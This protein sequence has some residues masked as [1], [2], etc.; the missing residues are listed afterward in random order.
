MAVFLFGVSELCSCFA[1]HLV[2]FIV[3]GFINLKLDLSSDM[4]DEQ[5]KPTKKN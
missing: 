4:L 1:H 5:P 2:T 3:T